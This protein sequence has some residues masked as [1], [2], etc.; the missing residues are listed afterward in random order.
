MHASS[1][2]PDVESAAIQDFF[3]RYDDSYVFYQT[4]ILLHDVR[5]GGVPEHVLLPVRL[6]N[7]LFGEM[8]LLSQHEE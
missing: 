7:I 8:L 6:E 3:L 1:T 5:A 2:R 4:R